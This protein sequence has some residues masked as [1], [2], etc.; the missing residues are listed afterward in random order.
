M[1]SRI[2]Y[3][4]FRF[5]FS[6]LFCG[7]CLVYRI[8]FSLTTDIFQISPSKK[9]PLFELENTGEEAVPIWQCARNA[10]AW[11]NK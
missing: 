10:N 5:F 6:K 11:K 2:F 3:A 8:F 9:K 4:N 1:K 7:T